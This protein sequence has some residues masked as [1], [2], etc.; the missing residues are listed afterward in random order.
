MPLSE[1][2]WPLIAVIFGLLLLALLLSGGEDVVPKTLM[3]V[4]FGLLGWR[5]LRNRRY[6]LLRRFSIRA[7]KLTEV[8]VVAVQG[9]QVTVIAD[10]AVART[11]VRINAAMETINSK[12]FFGEPFSVVV[13]DGLSP[14]SV[15]E[16]LSGPGVVY[17]RPDLLEE[18][19]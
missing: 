5:R 8:S 16:V 4:V 12:M 6:R 19:S 11:Y 14:E 17:V 2:N 3:V 18:A 1:W 7:Q 15:R 10:R 13:R 9:Q